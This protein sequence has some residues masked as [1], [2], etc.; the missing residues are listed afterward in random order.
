MTDETHA[1]LLKTVAI[2]KKAGAEPYGLDTS[3]SP[4]M[5]VHASMLWSEW[6]KIPHQRA[7]RAWS[8]E[9]KTDPSRAHTECIYG[10]IDGTRFM[11]FCS[12]P[13][14]DQWC[15]EHPELV[16][17]APEAAPVPA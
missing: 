11:T 15:L 10:E 17:S 1:A 6:L 3:M 2:L 5:R 7:W 8:A 12:P 16:T 4:P 13:V 14:W 9:S